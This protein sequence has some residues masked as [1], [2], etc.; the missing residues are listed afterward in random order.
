[1]IFFVPA[2]DE[3]TRANFTL[4]QLITTNSC[5]KI[6]DVNATEAAL[7][8]ELT[9]TT[10]PLFAMSHGDIDNTMPKMVKSLYQIK[11]FII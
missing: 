7:I 1:V 6:F 4:A 9:Q 5:L 10:L 11:I 2:Y 8:Q 3:C